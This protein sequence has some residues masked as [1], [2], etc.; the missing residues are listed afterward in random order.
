M[1]GL[2]R[3]HRNFWK[4]HI[5]DLY[6]RY[7]YE[8]VHHGGVVMPTECLRPRAQGGNINDAIGISAPPWYVCTAAAEAAAVSSCLHSPKMMLTTSMA[9][10]DEHDDR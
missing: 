1:V 6:S 3:G 9:F 4:Q 10:V 2:L 5:V 8:L 7:S